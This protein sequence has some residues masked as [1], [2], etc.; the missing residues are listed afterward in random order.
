MRTAAPERPPRGAIFQKHIA[1]PN[2]HGSWALWLA[3]FAVGAGVAG[4]LS[5]GTLWLALAAL[6]GFLALQPLTILVKVLSGRRART[7]LAAARFWLAAYAALGAAGALGLAWMGHAR[8]FWLGLAALPALAW[9]LWL[10]ARRAERG[11]MAAEIAGASALA[12]AAPAAY[13]VGGGDVRTGWLLW[14]LSWLHA[15]GAV[16]YV[17]LLLA[18]RRMAARPS[19][20]ERRVLARRAVLVNGFNLGLLAGLGLTGLVPLAAA[21]PFLG[22]LAEVL[23]GGLLS[24][25]VGV[26]PVVIGVRQTVVT[27][28]FAVLLILAYRVF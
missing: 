7:G 9:Y 26:R 21:V 11:Q 14:L 13:W 28:L 19:W 8:V 20:N 12:L 24:P 4:G 15:A 10:V 22:M 16:V 2:Q 1:L 6:G 3:P 17:Y 18:Y 5:A 25:P 23:H 27:A